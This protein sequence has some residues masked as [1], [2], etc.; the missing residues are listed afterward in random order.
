MMNKFDWKEAGELNAAFFDKGCQESTES[1]QAARFLSPDLQWAVYHT[2]T[3]KVPLDG[4]SLLDVGCGQGDLISFLYQSKKNVKSY[5][6]IDV[7]E[8]MIE[9]AAE[10]YGPDL[11]THGNFL[12]PERSFEVDVILAAGPYNYRVHSDNKVQFEYLKAAI[13]KMYSSSRRACA[14][15][16]LSSHGYEI[17]KDWTDLVCYEPWEVMQF[18]MTLTSSVVV[19]HASIPAEFTVMLYKET[20]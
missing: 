3:S 10:K 17:A 7:S 4:A 2:L 14:L 13:T 20:D 6:G 5:H 12:D 8:K 9:R 1:W 18:C 19:D 11:F 16:L 15:T